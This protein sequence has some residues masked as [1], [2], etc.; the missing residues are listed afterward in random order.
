V[1]L[2]VERHGSGEPLVLVHGVGTDRSVWR[3]AVPLLARER[4][5]IT[6]DLPGFGDS[7]PA[8]PG[9]PLDE[10]AEV[11]AAEG[12]APAGA[13]VDLLGAS[14]G[15][16]VAVAV[17]RRGPDLV[18]RLVLLS[19]AGF[20]PRPGAI[21]APAGL[22]AAGFMYGRR[23]VG[24]PL[25]G[26]SLARRALLW[27]AVHDGGRLSPD[28]ARAMVDASAG[29]KR[30]RQAVEEVVA[31]DLRPALAELEMPLGLIRGESD[32]VVPESVIREIAELRPGTPVEPIPEAGH[33]P[34]IERPAEFAAAV[35]RLLGR[36]NALG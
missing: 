25:V 19:P 24:A 18:R 22:V 27:G 28:D 31:L 17:A 13:P 6:L 29:A 5:V 2:A 15:G 36:M 33:V 9:F 34:Q 26:N 20:A 16:A 14:L 21:A 7:P 32:R 10:V 3:H 1:A 4:L 8:G 35:E 12:I 30:V 11:V 23:L